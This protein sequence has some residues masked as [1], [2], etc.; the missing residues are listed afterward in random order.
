MEGGGGGG[1]PCGGPEA[2]SLEWKEKQFHRLPRS[3]TDREWRTGKAEGTHGTQQCIRGE[4]VSR[5]P[6]GGVQEYGL[7]HQA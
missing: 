4:F 2:A 7:P 5:V 1:I 3:L 6:T